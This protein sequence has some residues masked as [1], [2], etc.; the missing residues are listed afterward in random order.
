[1]IKNNKG[2]SLVEIIVSVTLISMVIILLLSV[3]IT[4]RNE[5]ER[6][7]VLSTLLMNQAVITKE[8]EADFINLGLI[9][10]ASCDDG[11]TRPDRKDTVLSVIPA[12][13][14]LR[15]LAKGNCLKL[16][17]NPSSTSENTGYL[18]SYS[19]GFSDT[20][21]INVVGYRRG[22]KKVLRETSNL[23]EGFG[24][25]KNSCVSTSCTLRIDLPVL[26]DEGD[27]YG[28]HLS[29]LYKSS[30]NFTVTGLTNDIK[31]RFKIDN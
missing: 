26:S 5:D 28:I 19:Y 21:Q 22:D 9:G 2:M 14:S 10:V 18:L 31:Y 12:S 30:I 1:M 11:A 17:F 23:F 4:V 6:G 8:L 15:T 27:D 24:T 3:L 7:K 13:A 16:I 25:L 20:E 29:Y